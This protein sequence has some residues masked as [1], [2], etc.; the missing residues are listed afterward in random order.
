M[1]KNAVFTICARNYLAQALALK[2]SLKRSEPNLDFYL[3][4]SDSTDE[5]PND[6]DVVPL[7]E[8]WIP[9]WRSMAFKYNVI[10]FST[11][12]KPFFFKK[13]FGEGYSKV[14][15]LDP[16]TYITSSLQVIFDFLVDK[17]IVLTPHY[18]NVQT[19]YKGSITEEEILFVGIYNLGFAAIKNNLVGN[20]IIDWW[21]NR[22]TDKC[23]ADKYDALHVDQKWM[24]FIPAFFP[25]ETMI[26]HHMGINPAIW[27][28]HE[29]ELIVGAEGIYY[30]RNIETDELFPLIFFHFSGF[31][32]FNPTLINRRHPEYNTDIYPSYLPLFQQYIDDIYKNGYNSYSKLSY[33]FN[34]FDDGENIIPL[35]RRM[36]RIYEQDYQVKNPF[37][38]GNIFHQMLKKNKLLTG[39]KSNSFSTFSASSKKSKGIF[40]RSIIKGLNLIKVIV[41]IRYY[42]SL[43]NFLSIYVRYENQMFLIKRDDKGK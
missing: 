28:L 12:I 30:I 10:E 2:T 1:K 29:R 38:I 35:H 18:C 17:S 19:N 23:Y 6:I 33:S 16:D 21:M 34:S 9:D 27:N 4:I 36:L 25:T 32:P 5:L 26:T 3:F 40:E 7:D 41:G 24:D 31:D 39:I 43:L 20:K 15:Y 37:E 13:L 11:S 22:L 42:A 14:I 8:T